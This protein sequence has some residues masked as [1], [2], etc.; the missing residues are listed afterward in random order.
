MALL[1][2]TPASR[3]LTP[4][5][6]RTLGV[7]KG[8]ARPDILPLQIMCGGMGVA[9]EEKAPPVPL[10]KYLLWDKEWREA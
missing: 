1:W 6:S 3:C 7:P 2:P 5:H 10:V 9:N 8:K 4:S